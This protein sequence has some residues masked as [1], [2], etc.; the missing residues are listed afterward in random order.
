VADQ[1]EPPAGQESTTEP[2]DQ[3][4]PTTNGTAHPED[5]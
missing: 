5:M 3:S 2:E 4:E 1:D